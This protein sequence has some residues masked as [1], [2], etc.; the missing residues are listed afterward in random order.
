MAKKTKITID[1]YN[2][3]AEEYY[4]I[5]T[6][7]EVLPEL[8]QFLSFLN[9]CDSILDLGCGPGHHSDFFSSKGYEV[10][11]ID[12][13]PEMLEIAKKETPQ[14]DFKVMDI[15]DLKFKENSFHGIW[16]SASLLHVPK[17]KI[18]T[19]LSKI[20]KL[21][22]KDGVFYLS[23]K[24]GRGSRIIKDDRYGG[25]NKYYVYYREDE[26]KRYLINAGF[27]LIESKERAKRDKYDTN[28][29]IH[30]F[31]KKK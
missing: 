3:T 23:L 22:K 19:V 30:V 2:K 8:D 13:S 11:G 26:I 28:P 5:V 6:K 7:F 17:R 15:Q 21:L 31:C 4:K 27:E 20:Y 25:V 29:W 14:V 1:G 24:K 16:A 18:K 10:I 9:P 12:L